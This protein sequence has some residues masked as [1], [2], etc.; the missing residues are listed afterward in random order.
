MTL[1]LLAMA[2]ALW[3]LLPTYVANGTAPLS[4]GRGP[5]MD[6]GRKWPGDGRP[7]LGQSKTWAGFLIGGTIGL[8]VGLF[9]QYLLLAAPPSLQIVPAFAASLGSAVLPVALI[10]YGALIGDALGSFVKRR[11]GMES[12][13]RS[14][15]LDQLPFILVPMA[16]IGVFVPNLFLT[17]F[18]PGG[19]AGV[20]IVSWV[21]ILSL[22]LHAGFN[23]VG[24]FAGLKKVPW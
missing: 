23:L 18:W 13:G 3:V 14:P 12:G 11:I 10:S 6:F 21:V 2:G 15:L 22:F 1:W 4:L 8:L 5:K 16:L 20:L 24:Y 9:E 7:W 17:A 19:M